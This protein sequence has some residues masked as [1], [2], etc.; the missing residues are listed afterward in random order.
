MH[1]LPPLCFA[2]A[3]L[4]DCDLYVDAA[5]HT[6]ILTVHMTS[7]LDDK[8]TGCGYNAAVISSCYNTG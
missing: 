8:H 6:L 2:A 7:L 5:F 3:Y 4:L 1:A